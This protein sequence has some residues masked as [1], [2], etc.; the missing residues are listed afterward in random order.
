MVVRPLFFYEINLTGHRF[1]YFSGAQNLL[2]SDAHPNNMQESELFFTINGGIPLSFRKS[3]LMKLGADIGANF[4][5]YFS[6]PDFTSTDTP[7]KFTFRYISPSFTIN[8]NTLDHKQYPMSGNNRLLNFRYI[9]GQE[10][11]IP[12]SRSKSNSRVD[13]VPHSMF[14][15][16]FSDE[17]YYRIGTRFSLGVLVDITLGNSALMSDYTSTIMAQPAF[18]PTSHSKTLM[19]EQYRADTY[20]GVGL[21]PIVRFTPTVSLHLSGFFF[22]PYQKTMQDNLGNLYRADPFSVSSRMAAASLVWQSPAGPVSLSANYY[23][24]ETNKLYTQLNI[25]YMIFKRKALSR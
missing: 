25:G 21:M 22:L 12:D 20:L 2:Y 10:S 9:F 5:T 7:N 14:T 3:Y 8:R 24:K 1:D 6:V 17:N 11:F 4:M 23:D 19:L 13:H 18:Q 16:R 15:A